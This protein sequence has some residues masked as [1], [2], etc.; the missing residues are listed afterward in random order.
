M[1]NK[2]EN[3]RGGGSLCN[4][5]TRFQDQGKDKDQNNDELQQELIPKRETCSQFPIYPSL[6]LFTYLSTVS[7]V[8]VLIILQQLSKLAK[9][10]EFKVG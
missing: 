2:N 9:R 8:H 6:A 4:P 3:N 7:T 5:E 10:K 1:D